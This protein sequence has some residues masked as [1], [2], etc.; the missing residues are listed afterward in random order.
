MSNWSDYYINRVGE[1]YAKYCQDR[2]AVY[3]N[4]V[5][6]LEGSI[7]EEGCGIG[8]MSR[9]FTAYNRRVA[10]ISD[11]DIDMAKL[12]A[13][14]TGLTVDIADIRHMHYEVNPD[15]ICSHGVLEHFSD[16]DI[17]RIINRQRAQAN[18]RVIH[19][20]PSDKYEKGSFGDERLMSPTQW[21]D[22]VNPD[23]I[24]AFNDE[25]DLVLLWRGRHE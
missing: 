9:I 18:K 4:S 8:T 15:I 3:I 22:L 12:A 17:V 5:I 23:K 6:E 25:K 10:R 2:Y 24:V 1:S 21:I 20:V 16:S 7:S 11:M 19:Y 13:K 14:N